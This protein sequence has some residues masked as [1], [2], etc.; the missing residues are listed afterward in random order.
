MLNSQDF[1][2]LLF[3]QHQNTSITFISIVG[4]D[5]KQETLLN[6]AAV[7]FSK[8]QNFNQ[9][10]KQFEFKDFSPRGHLKNSTFMGN[11]VNQEKFKDKE[12][13]LTFAWFS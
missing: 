4:L 10:Q 2:F 8:W 12:F 11:S 5:L 7:W 1:M 6:I 13:L 9:M 3:S